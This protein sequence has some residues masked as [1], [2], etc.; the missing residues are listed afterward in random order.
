MTI[1]METRFIRPV[2][3]GRLRATATT[4]DRTRTTAIL[5][6]RIYNANNDL[7]ALC[8]STFKGVNPK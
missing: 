2:Q 7:I 6:G 4:I 3:E 5:E 1:Q 8:T